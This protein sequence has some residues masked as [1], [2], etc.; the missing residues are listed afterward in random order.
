MDLHYNHNQKMRLVFILSH[1]ELVSGQDA[2]Y[3]NVKV[4]VCVVTTVLQ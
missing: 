2:G 4:V 3:L 1:R